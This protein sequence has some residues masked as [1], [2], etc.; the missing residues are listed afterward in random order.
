MR[1]SADYVLEVPSDDSN[2]SQLEA[3]S[4]V[5]GHAVICLETV[6]GDSRSSIPGSRGNNF[7]SVWAVTHAA[8]KEYEGHCSQCLRRRMV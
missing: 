7:R 8:L 2:P 3:A 6:G 1:E 4:S 5:V